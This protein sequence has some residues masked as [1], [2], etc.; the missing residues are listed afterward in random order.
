[1]KKF[2]AIAL[3]AALITALFAGCGNDDESTTGTTTTAST[4][5][6]TTTEA[7]TTEATTTEATTTEATLGSGDEETP[8]EDN[9][10]A[11]E[12]SKI[13]AALGELSSM[14]DYD[15]AT[16]KD[17]YGTDRSN[18][19][20]FAG[21]LPLMNVKAT[22]IAVVEF[23]EEVTQAQAEEFFKTRL[24]S[25]EST[26]ATYLPDQYELVKNAKIAVKGNI[27]AMVIAENADAGIEAFNE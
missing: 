27:A 21:K 10:A 1:M 25:L 20:S 17:M 9:A 19:K 6:A 26:W 16:F 23:N 14:M 13:E 24:D 22:E 8:S 3:S 11:A 18:V 15:E 4:T 2:L 5:E 12:L 7:T